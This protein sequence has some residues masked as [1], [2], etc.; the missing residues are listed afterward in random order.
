MSLRDDARPEGQTG[1]YGIRAYLSQSA[2]VDSSPVQT[3]APFLYSL[4]FGDRGN[5]FFSQENAPDQ[6]LILK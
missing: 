4:G 5:A 2:E 6:P 1:N 3:A